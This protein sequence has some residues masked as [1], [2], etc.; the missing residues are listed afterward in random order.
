MGNAVGQFSNPYGVCLG[1][2][3]GGGDRLLYVCDV[4]NHRIQVFNAISGE[5]Y[6]N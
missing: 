6:E 2:A 4:E 5:I 1:P 3:P